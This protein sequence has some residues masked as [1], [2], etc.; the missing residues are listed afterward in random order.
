MAAPRNAVTQRSRTLAMIMSP[1]VWGGQRGPPHDCHRLELE[2]SDEEADALTACVAGT[3]DAVVSE[4]ADRARQVV[5]GRRLGRIA[6][7]R[8]AQ[9]HAIENIEELGANVESQSFVK[10]ELTAEVHVLAHLMRSA[11]V[12]VIAGAGADLSRADILPRRRIENP[13]VDVIRIDAAAIDV[14]QV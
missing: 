5:D 1:E 12:T 2:T 11:I 4:P 8:S 6:G 9:R 10:L 13:L 3:S 14:R 7:T